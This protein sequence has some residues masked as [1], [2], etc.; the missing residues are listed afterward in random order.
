MVCPRRGK[1]I[2]L[3]LLLAAGCRSDAPSPAREFLPPGNEVVVAYDLTLDAQATPEQVAWV[4]LQALREDLRHPVGS[5]PWR[6]VMALECRLADVELLRAQLTGARLTAEEREH[7]IYDLVKN[8]AAK[9]HYY[10]PGLEGEFAA[11][12][13]RMTVAQAVDLK[14]PAGHQQVCQVAYT[15]GRD[16]ADPPAAAVVVIKMSRSPADLWR[17]YQVHI[18]PPARPVS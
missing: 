18:Q 14:L 13:R 6:E 5:S 8:W 3:G 10:A 2:A 1:C 17:V 9:V 11:A 4:L 15:A 7:F 12:R 16:P